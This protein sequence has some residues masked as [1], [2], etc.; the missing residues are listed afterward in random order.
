MD[1]IKCHHTFLFFLTGILFCLEMLDIK[2][3]VNAFS[4]WLL[5]F[6]PFKSLWLY[7]KIIGPLCFW[8][9]LLF[10]IVALVAT[11][12]NCCFLCV[13]EFGLLS[14][15][16]RCFMVMLIEWVKWFQIPVSA[17]YC[18]THLPL[19]NR[20][21]QCMLCSAHTPISRI[22]SMP[23]TKEHRESHCCFMALSGSCKLFVR[24]LL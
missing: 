22:I 23:Q 18:K 15:V 17:L 20:S 9:Y 21:H 12:I 2:W 4:C 16:S 14:F 24:T 3:V 6:C 10:S 8:F 11:E 13:W 7:F 19:Y 5:A 1:K